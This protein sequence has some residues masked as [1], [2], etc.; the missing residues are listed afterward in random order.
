M[1]TR[2][3]YRLYGRSKL[4]DLNSYSY[5]ERTFLFRRY[6][7]S[8]YLQSCYLQSRLLELHL[9]F[10]VFRIAPFK[11]KK[12]FIVS[13]HA[14]FLIAKNTNRPNYQLEGSWYGL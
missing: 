6:L 3:L 7:P 10:Y 8:S 5:K 12:G 13:I 1:V 4:L 11:T 14:L 2:S 9:S